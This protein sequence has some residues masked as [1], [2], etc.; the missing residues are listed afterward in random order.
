MRR[1]FAVMLQFLL[2]P[3]RQT[4]MVCVGERSDSS[5]AA[6]IRKERDDRRGGGWGRCSWSGEDRGC[7]GVARQKPD[8]GLNFI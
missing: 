3:G 5:H 7:S 8:L 2:C 4:L 1:R 6:K